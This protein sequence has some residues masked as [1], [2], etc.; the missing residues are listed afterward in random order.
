MRRIHTM[1]DQQEGFQGP[2]M[3]DRP[4][5]SV[6]GLT[7]HFFG[8]EGTT[9]AVDGVSF[10]VLPGKT[11]GIVGES[12]CGKSVMARSIL[13]IVEPPG[14]IVGGE[15]VLDR[16]GTLVDLGQLPEDGEEIRAV[17]GGDIGLVFQEPMTSFS[18]V[19]TVG[20]Q[21]TEAIRL[22]LRLAKPE[23]HERAVELL[24][25]TEV[26][27]PEEILGS[28][29]WELSGG[30]RQRAMIAM[31]LAGDPKLLIADE[32][33]TALDVTTQ[34]QILELIRD[35]Q[36]RTGMAIM[37]ITHDL[38]V[39][40]T[41]ADDVAV[42]YLG[43]VVERGP[44]DDIF[45][46]PKHPY[47]RGLL[48]SIPSIYAPSRARLATI[49]G[50]VPHPFD[51]PSGCSFHARCTQAISGVCNK[52]DP[53]R[54]EIDEHR[55]VTCHIYADGAAAPAGPPQPA[56]APFATVTVAAAASV[57]PANG[58]TAN[59]GTAN[60]GTANGD[61]T[62][63][64]TAN[65]DTGNGDAAAPRLNGADRL[66]GRNVLEVRNLRKF[67]PVQSGQ[68]GRV[69]GYVRAVDDIDFDLKEGETLALVGE[70]G[71]G[72]TTTS[73]C[74]LR[75]VDPDSGQILFRTKSGDA[76]DLAK[77]SRKRVRPLRS[78][79][80]MIFQDPHSSLNPRMT[81]LDIVGEPLLVN[82]M[83]SRE[84]RT[85]RVREL[86]ELVG[87]RKEYMQRFPHAFSGGQRQRIGIA[88][89]LALNPRLIVADEP[90]SA[91]DVSVQAQT[92]NLL[93]T[94]QEEL[95]L[96][97]LFVS[98]DLSVVKHISDRIAVMYGGQLVELGEREEVLSEPKHPYTSTL[99][100]AIP[101]P[102]PRAKTAIKA[103]PRGG[104]V[105]LVDPPAGCYFQARCRYAVEQCKVE[106]PVWREISPGRRVR[107]HRADELALS[108]VS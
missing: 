61:A 31:A 93:V 32:P 56:D 76:V 44:V 83:K 10:D 39:I 26:P 1:S 55:E 88:R 42:M 98:H 95:G 3:S 38:G 90:V 24:R 64:G 70:S 40:A 49:A 59:G 50:S 106:R 16:D 102:D 85:E 78:Q 105:N 108:G 86:L 43:K 58:G 74:V 101:K 84:E 71:S 94:L 46:A 29:A 47:T 30:L 63:G 81:I 80:Q 104:V 79:L 72:K 20:N 96:T 23:A 66:N 97:Y 92:L 69:R 8:D 4:L 62:N 17:R 65:P 89:A 53:V 57:D 75:A 91:L 100:A 35:L 9:K 51:R 103:P 68:L 21:I 12:G 87:M 34:A 37:F 28:Y 48:A 54:L 2:N 19:H 45:H 13:R 67:F 18:P 11:L 60:G 73:R 14:R 6:R 36:A 82:G 27:R 107:C 15:L 25:M 22:H 7:T 33:T 52:R 99:L 77:L 5:L 41:L